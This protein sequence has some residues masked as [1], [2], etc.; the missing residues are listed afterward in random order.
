MHKKTLTRIIDINKQ[1][2]DKARYLQ[3]TNKFFVCKH[4]TVK[5]RNKPDGLD[6]EMKLEL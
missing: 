2:N 3:V 6:L 5:P 4:N 1:N